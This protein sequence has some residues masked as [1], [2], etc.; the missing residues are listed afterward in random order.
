MEG[1]R[2]NLRV[3]G[4]SFI[5]QPGT[6][7]R[8]Y[9]RPG[10]ARSHLFHHK[11]CRFSLNTSR[12]CSAQHKVCAEQITTT[13]TVVNTKNPKRSL[14]CHRFYCNVTGAVKPDSSHLNSPGA[15]VGMY[16]VATPSMPNDH[17]RALGPVPGGR[18][19]GSRSW[20]RR[21][22]VTRVSPMLTGGTQ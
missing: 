14:D 22:T 5:P 3:S 1:L 11:M 12:F 17:M 16:R 4:G 18:A 20:R 9:P 21:E 13:T 10:Q 8:G 15:S 19:P 6:A 7:V 2:R